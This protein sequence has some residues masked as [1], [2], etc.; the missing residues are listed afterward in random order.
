MEVSVEFCSIQ[1]EI[2]KP[3]HHLFCLLILA[4]LTTSLASASDWQLFASSKQNGTNWYYDKDG[5]VYFRA[6]SIAGVEI[7]MKDTNYIRIWIKSADYKGER[8]YRVEL[9]CKQLTAQLQ[10]NSGKTLYSE[11]SIDYF[12]DKPLVPDSVLDMLRKTVCH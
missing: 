1:G 2:M 8:A 11:P 4:V 9:N 7:P 3:K 5:I 12:Y 10:D 6:K